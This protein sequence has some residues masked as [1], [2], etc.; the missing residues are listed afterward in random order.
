[1]K[2][3]VIGD[4]HNH[5]IAAEKLARRYEET[6]KI[7][8]VGDYF[9]D[10]Y[11]NPSVAIDTAIWLKES[12]HK[13]NRIHLYGNHDLQYT[14]YCE[15][16]T[17]SK[18][19]KLYMCSGYTSEKDDAVKKIL[20]ID[21]WCK[22][23]LHHFEYGIHFTHAGAAKEFFEHPIKGMTNETILETIKKA[24]TRFYNREQSDIIGGAGFCRGGMN[25]V[26]GITWNDHNQEANPV[27]DIT[28]VYGHTPV[29]D[30]DILEDNGGTNIDVDCGLSQ[31][32]EISEDGK[33]SIID[34]EFDSF[35]DHYNNKNNHWR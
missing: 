9:D 14:P 5:V 35:Y 31:I 33:F 12:L 15:I 2:I 26:G 13:P 1:M 30:I 16:K 32:L 24:E 22:M 19:S 25:P 11:D 8:F 27:R 29:N 34:T 23:K 17:N 20:N 10:F 6:H 18:Y 4:I 7:L 28:Q 21:D 3:I